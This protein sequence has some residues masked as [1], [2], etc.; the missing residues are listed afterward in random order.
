MQYFDIPAHAVLLVAM[1]KDLQKQAQ[2][3]VAI[4]PPVWYNYLVESSSACTSAN[5]F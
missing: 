2:N 5:A 3:G 4:L 1:Q